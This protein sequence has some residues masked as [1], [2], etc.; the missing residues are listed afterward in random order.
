MFKFVF[1]VFL[2][3]LLTSCQPPKIKSIEG[4]A[5]GERKEVNG[6]KDGLVMVGIGDSENS[7]D[8]LKAANLLADR[9]N[10]EAIQIYKELC[11]KEKPSDKTFAFLGLG[12]AYLADGQYKAALASFQ[13]S[14]RLDGSNVNAIVSI[15]S[16]YY[17]M[18]RFDSAIVYYQMGKAI[19]PDNSSSYWGLAISYDML[20]NKILARQNA[21]E[22]IKRE[23]NSQYRSMLEI[24]MNK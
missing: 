9:K 3:C 17:S 23:P 18:K 5:E 6:Q 8:Y 22:F 13:N 14:I 1:S 21:K 2:I 20:S 10:D 7:V 19:D 11:A 12:S 15:G 16:T 4:L 24:I